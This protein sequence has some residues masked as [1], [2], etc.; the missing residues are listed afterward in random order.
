MKDCVYLNEQLVLFG[1]QCGMK[2]LQVRREV[3]LQETHL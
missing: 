1:L 3:L 2:R